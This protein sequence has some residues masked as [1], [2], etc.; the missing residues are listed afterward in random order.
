MA[1]SAGLKPNQVSLLSVAVSL[2]AAVLL[3]GSSHVESNALRVVMLLGAAAAIQLRLLCNLIDGLMA[4]EGNMKSPSGAIYNDLPDRVSDAITLVAA[5]YAARAWPWAL[6]LGWLAALLAVLTAYV[7][8]LGASAAPHV[9]HD[10]RG[11]MAK[12]QRM[13]IITIAGVLSIAEPWL[14]WRTGAVLY[15]SLAIIA[16]GCC[17]TIVR[18]SRGTLAKLEALS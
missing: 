8:V 18:R 2:I 10:F 4:V 12:Q 16:L 13:A 7:R 6:E 15:V 14:D 1:I 9:G 3:G 17:M 5:G 11:P